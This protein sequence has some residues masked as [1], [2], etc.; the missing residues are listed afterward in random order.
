M[1]FEID[2][3]TRILAQW[4][5]W[6]ITTLPPTQQDIELLPGGLTN[7]C[8][9]LK[10]NQEKFVIRSESPD[11]QALGIDRDAEFSI[12]QFA[13]Q[14]GWVANIIFR[15]QDERYWI[16]PFIEGQPLIRETLTDDQIRN[17]AVR[18]GRLH[19]VP[20]ST[21][22]NSHA[23]PIGAPKTVREL[24]VISIPNQADRLWKQAAIRF[25]Q[26]EQE[27]CSRGVAKE[28]CDTLTSFDNDIETVSHQVE[29]M[30]ARIQSWGYSEWGLCHMD[31]SVANWLQTP[32]GWMLLDWEYAGLGDG[33]WDLAIFAD[34]ANLNARQLE[35]LINAYRQTRSSFELDVKSRAWV[36]A[37]IQ[38][39][40]LLALWFAAQ[41]METIEGLSRKLADLWLDVMEY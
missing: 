27:M 28:H 32:Q 20:L 30:N 26:S 23:L 24:P 35:V 34:D 16:R 13:A 21:V 12:H 41:G 10:V 7:R 8:C 38:T 1:K 29:Q 14:N 19:E 31:P 3:L 40:Y 9:V 25:H 5:D 39:Q 33:L 36:R 2:N 6:N 22:L 4:A 17:V 15:N 37:N 11:S 18:L